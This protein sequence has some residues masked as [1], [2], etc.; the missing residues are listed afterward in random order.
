MTRNQ[1]DYWNYVENSRHNQEVERETKRSNKAQLQEQRRANE[2]REYENERTNRANEAIR[3]EANV[4]NRG[5]TAEIARHNYE[6]EAA[7]VRSQDIERQR[8]ALGY[9]Q[10]A[11][12][13]RIATIQAGVGYANVGATYASISEQQRANMARE[14]ENTRHNLETEGVSWAQSD[15]AGSNAVANLLNA[16]TRKGEL[17]LKQEQWSKIGYDQAQANLRL[18]VQ[19]G[20]TQIAQRERMAHQNM[21]DS[22]NAGAN[23]LGSAS[24][25]ISSAKLFKGGV[26]K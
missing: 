10:S 16:Q 5:A 12:S 26:K 17:Q 7:T 15:V 11:V 22:I 23:V 6:Q 25:L 4:I 1:I 18:T 14:A 13:E 8:V 21:T 19:Q 20:L 24:R 2:A 3:R 9:A